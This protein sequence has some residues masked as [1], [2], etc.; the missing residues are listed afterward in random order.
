MNVKVVVAY[1]K[2]MDDEKY[3]FIQRNT[4]SLDRE[5]WLMHK[6]VQSER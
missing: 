6:A 2:Y 5:L 4:I 3:F 1:H